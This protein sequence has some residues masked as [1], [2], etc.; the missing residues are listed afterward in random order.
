MW[1][2]PMSGGLN[3][4]YDGEVILLKDRP[5]LA[6]ART[7]AHELGQAPRGLPYAQNDRTT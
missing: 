1:F 4:S 3:G 7:A 5:V 2:R 6:P